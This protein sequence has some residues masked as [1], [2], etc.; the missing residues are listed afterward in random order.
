M[1][2]LD[3]AAVLQTIHASVTSSFHVTLWCMLLAVFASILSAAWLELCTCELQIERIQNRKLYQHYCGSKHQMR[4]RWAHD[5]SLTL[6]RDFWHG[7]K[8]AD[9]ARI[10]TDEYGMLYS[11]AYA[12]LQV[13]VRM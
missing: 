3:E 1:L 2:C 8:S 10:D 11:S 4:E 7:T 12:G 6:E 9:P 13:C 5:P